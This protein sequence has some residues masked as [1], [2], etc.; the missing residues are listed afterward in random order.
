MKTSL[1]SKGFTLIEMMII[2]LIIGLL[3]GILVP[4]M[5]NAIKKSA[6]G[7]S[8]GNLATLRSSVRI[9]YAAHDGTYP[10]DNL[11]SLVPDYITNIPQVNTPGYHGSTQ[12]VATETALTDSGNWSYN[13]DSTT[14]GFGNV[15]VGCTHTELK[16]QP[17]STY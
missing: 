11:A 8:K 4:Q 3:V 9:Y 7:N 5:G 1:S 6:E 2:V 14:A 10:T 12:I 17:W 15:Y 13:N 16:G